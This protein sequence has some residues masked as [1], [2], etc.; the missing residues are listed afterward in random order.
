MN[1]RRP[2]TSEVEVRK[3][4]AWPLPNTRWTK[5]YL[6]G[7]SGESSLSWERPEKAA[8]IQVDAMGKPVTFVSEPLT[9][10]TEVTG[11]LTAKLFI[12]SSTSDADLF[13]TFQAFSAEGREVEFQGTVDPHTPLAQG[14]LR[15][16]H[17]K[18]DPA[19][20]I[21]YRPYHSHDELQ[22]LTPGERYEVDVEVWPANIV[23]PAVFRLA[24][25]ISGQDFEREVPEGA[26]EAWAAKGSGPWLHNLV[27]DRPAS[28]FGGV[29]TVHAG[30]ESGSY[31]LLP[32]VS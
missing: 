12:S 4:H 27:E 31:L 15:A 28:V 20:S 29:T 18:L 7:H 3:A 14:W 1:V 21:P 8:G 16:S 30:S 22:P 24:L 13:L 11:P 9:Q 23:L 32:V 25:Q 2:F 26:N 6:D 10:E 5:M 19:R 17:R